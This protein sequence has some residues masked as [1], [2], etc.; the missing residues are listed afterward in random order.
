MEEKRTQ[1]WG[2]RP[3]AYNSSKGEP[4]NKCDHRDFDKLFEDLQVTKEDQRA[5]APA[6][7]GGAGAKHE[8]EKQHKSMSMDGINGS[9][10]PFDDSPPPTATRPRHDNDYSERDYNHPRPDEEAAAS[11]STK[12]TR[13]RT[14]C[15]S[16]VEVVM[17]LSVVLLLLLAFILIA[18]DSKTTK[19]G[20][21]LGQVTLKFTYFDAFQYLLS[22]SMIAC[23]FSVIQLV[24]ELYRMHTGEVLIPENIILYFNFICDQFLAYLLLSSTSA[25]MT[26]SNLVR[27]GYDLVWLS[28][29]SGTGFWSFCAQAA[30]SVSM[31]FLAFLIM[32]SL[33]LLSGYRLAKYLV[34]A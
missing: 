16:F 6:G 18:S 17:R 9:K 7:T 12:L 21:V 22:A 13:A 33:A 31:A 20:Y 4:A 2:T 24:P 14:L 15:S 25:G 26:A 10:N 32:A 34:F 19:I 29:C 5:A 1:P 23:G 3:A 27:K 11:P 8:K 28:L 30:A